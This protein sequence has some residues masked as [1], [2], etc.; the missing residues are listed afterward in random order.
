MI[1]LA[2]KLIA[3]V[4]LYESHSFAIPKGNEHK[5]LTGELECLFKALVWHFIKVKLVFISISV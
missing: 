1:H 4:H 3:E 2:K 5:A